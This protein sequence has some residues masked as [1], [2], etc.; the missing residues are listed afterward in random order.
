MQRGA[1][2]KLFIEKVVRGTAIDEDL[3]GGAVQTAGEND[4]RMTV[5]C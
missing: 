1:K 4:K 2:G 5:G 3:G